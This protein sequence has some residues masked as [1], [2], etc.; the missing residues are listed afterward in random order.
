MS[1]QEARTEIEEA[2]RLASSGRGNDALFAAE[3]AIEHYA[4]DLLGIT[5]SE[6]RSRKR[7]GLQEG[8]ALRQAQ[9]IS[10]EHMELLE[11][12]RRVRNVAAHPPFTITIEGRSLVRALGKL[13]DL[14]EREGAPLHR[15]AIRDLYFA[16]PDTPAVE[17]AAVMAAKDYSFVPVLA[18]DQP[19]GTV[20]ERAI[21]ELFGDAGSEMSYLDRRVADIMKPPLAVHGGDEL[22]HDIIGEVHRNGAILVRLRGSL[23]IY[24]IWDYVDHGVFLKN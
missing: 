23:G 6:L 3:R 21:V 10:S 14:I 18:E 15:V 8:P 13:Q 1:W 16:E 20:N 7:S 5:I 4:S 19:V 12:F 2:K 22:V 24:T 17:V 9:L 11:G